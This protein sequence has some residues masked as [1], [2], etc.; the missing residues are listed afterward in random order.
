MTFILPKKY[1]ASAALFSSASN[2]IYDLI[3]KPSFGYEQQTDRLIQILTSP[4]MADTLIANLNLYTY[5]EL[6][7]SNENAHNQIYSRL[8]EDITIERNRNLAVEITATTRSA[9]LSRDMV[10]HL[11]DALGTVHAD[12]IKQNTYSVVEHYQ[13]KVDELQPVVD[14]LLGA[15][16]TIDIRG[17]SADPLSS[18]RFKEIE[19]R[20]THDVVTPADS[21]IAALMSQT[22]DKDDQNLIDT[23]VFHYNNLRYLKQ[24]LVSAR[25]SLDAPVPGINIINRA[26]LNTQP[27]SPSLIKVLLSAILLGMIAAAGIVLI[28]EKVVKA[29]NA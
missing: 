13:E 3:N 4:R 28:R 5:Y 7:S 21:Y 16:Y 17:G 22:L 24:E 19:H 26:T 9:E 29:S 27:V 15:I 1:E 20:M 6:D 8:G 23:Y 18:H 14:S 10:N 11:L 25:N 12:I 2:S